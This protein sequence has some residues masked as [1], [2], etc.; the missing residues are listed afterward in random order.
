MIIGLIGYGALGI[1][2]ENMLLESGIRK[3]Q[4]IY[5]DDSNAKKF[6][7]HPFN[8]YLDDQFK[9]INFIVGLGY[10]HLDLKKKII[11]SL[12]EKNRKLY[13][14]IHKSSYINPTAKIGKGVVIY[15]G[16]NIDYMVDIANGVVLNNS[17]TVSHES[18]I[19][20]C[21]FIAPGVIINGNVSIGE[22]SFIGSRSVISN[23]VS[24]GNHVIVGIASCVTNSIQDN[25]HCIGNP[26]QTVKEIKLQ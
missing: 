15:P 17:V 21:S 14:F 7:F 19:G 11:S 26:L 9:E 10:K 2:V 12:A 24:V 23:K 20:S 6:N 8:N 5:F 18:K 13:S 1:Q 25:I 3:D 22:S 16:C 4:F